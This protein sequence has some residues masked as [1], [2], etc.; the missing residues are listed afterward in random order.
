MSTLPKDASD[1][2]RAVTAPRDLGMD[3]AD[4]DRASRGLVGPFT[5]DELRY[6]YFAGPHHACIRADSTLQ[7]D[8]KDVMKQ[9]HMVHF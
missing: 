5:A 6:N 2:T 9:V 8:G 3:P 7:I 1:H 4:F